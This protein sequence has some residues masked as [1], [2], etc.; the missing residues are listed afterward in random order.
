MKD[1][2]DVAPIL[3]HS[4]CLQIFMTKYAV[5]HYF[6]YHLCTHLSSF[7]PRSHIAESKT[8]HLCH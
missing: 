8:I 5:L 7:S 2:I 6:V 4:L 1:D 3:G